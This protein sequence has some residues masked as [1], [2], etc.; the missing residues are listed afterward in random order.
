MIYSLS[1]SARPDGVRVHVR[2]EVDLSASGHLYDVLGDALAQ[3]LGTVEV[4]LRGLQFLDC[5]GITA[6]L[7]ARDDARR[8]GQVLFVSRPR[9][10]V[11]LVL[12]LTGT[13]SLLTAETARA[14]SPPVGADLYLLGAPQG[15]VERAVG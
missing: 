7:R 5:S 3:S 4:D 11:R 15:R 2:G 8:S 12:E 10:T 9:G 13:L 6:L 1:L 14:P